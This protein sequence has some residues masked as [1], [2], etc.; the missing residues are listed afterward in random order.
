MLFQIWD[1]PD[2]GEFIR[3]G[4]VVIPLLGERAGVRVG[5]HLKG[6]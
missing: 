6:D 4:R 3:G 5:I 1:Q 2:V